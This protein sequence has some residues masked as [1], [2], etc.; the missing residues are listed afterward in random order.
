MKIGLFAVDHGPKA[1]MD[2]LSEIDG[3][4]QFSNLEILDV[5]KFDAIVVGTSGTQYGVEQEFKVR[6]IAT[7]FR[8]PLIIIED[9]LCNF[10]FNDKCNPGLLIVEHEYSRSRHLTHKNEKTKI[11]V[12]E[13]PRYDEFRRQGKRIIEAISNEW[14]NNQNLSVLWAGQPETASMIRTLEKINPVL[15]EMGVKLLFKAHP[16]DDGYVKGT[17]DGIINKMGDLWQDVTDI[18]LSTCVKRFVPRIVL[19]H[20]SSLAIESGFYGVPC[21]NI[22]CDESD[23]AQLF[24][25]K[26]YKLPP[27]CDEGAAGIIQ[28]FTE[29]KEKLRELL[30]NDELRKS[31][32]I[33]FYEWFGDEPTSNEVANNILRFINDAREF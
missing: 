30:F 28:N 29:F 27:W 19:T 12:I 5:Q 31:I 14:V 16:G 7:D 1:V 23:K 10:I 6:Q 25:V 32:N 8:I 2:A 24:S 18:E 33:K 13:N 22:L 21:L 26:G 20:F 3:F 4:Y 15:L 11:I 17:Y 9:Y